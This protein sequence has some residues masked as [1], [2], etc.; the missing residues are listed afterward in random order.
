MLHVDC[1]NVTTR[2]LS[3]VGF[4]LDA[5]LCEE[6]LHAFPGPGLLFQPSREVQHLPLQVLQPVRPAAAVRGHGGGH[7]GRKI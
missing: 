4:D 6:V 2:L 7:G 1:R 5:G 3:L